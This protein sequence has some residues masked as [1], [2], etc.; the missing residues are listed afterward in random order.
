MLRL[1]QTAMS[2]LGKTSC[3][4]LS[5]MLIAVRRASRRRSWAPTEILGPP[6]FRAYGADA[7]APPGVEIAR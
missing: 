5:A 4:A 6:A 1:L 3:V 7:A 2:A